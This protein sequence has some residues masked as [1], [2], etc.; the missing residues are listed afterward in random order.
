MLCVALC[1][2]VLQLV[3]MAREKKTALK[4]APAL[5][6]LARFTSDQLQTELDYLREDECATEYTQGGVN[7]LLVKLRKWTEQV[8]ADIKEQEDRDETV[9]NCKKKTKAAKDLLLKDSVKYVALLKASLEEISL[10][11]G[12][13]SRALDVPT[14]QGPKASSFGA[15][16]DSSTVVTTK[17]DEGAGTTEGDEGAGK[18]T[19]EG[20]EGAGKGTTES[21][22]DQDATDEGDIDEGAGKGTTDEGDIDEGAGKG[23]TDEGDID[24]GDDTELEEAK[25]APKKAAP[26]QKA[27]PKKAAPKK[28]ALSAA[29]V[30]KAKNL[31]LQEAQDEAL[32][33]SIARQQETIQLSQISAA[34]SRSSPAL[35]VPSPLTSPARAPI[36]QSLDLVDEDAK[37]LASVKL[38]H[39]ISEDWYGSTAS[40]PCKAIQGGHLTGIVVV[41]VI[42]LNH[43]VSIILSWLSLVPNWLSIIPNFTVLCLLSYLRSKV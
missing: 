37:W 6:S 29:A 22:G 2:V 4:S 14:E 26:R 9:K 20:D 42:A 39:K 32:A 13:L 19:T 1:C 23:T 21:E 24:E 5:K 25:P 11:T 35:L 34:E 33:Q 7:R 10:K 36:V 30:K 17:G 43:L 28:K 16:F 15:G 40:V 12:W 3:G 8:Y 18:G 31:L 38:K 41:V 27:A